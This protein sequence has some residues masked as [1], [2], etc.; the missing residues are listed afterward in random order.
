MRYDFYHERREYKLLL[1]GDLIQKK[2]Q[3]NQWSVQPTRS[4]EKER[5]KVDN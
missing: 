5:R 2:K 1:I 4:T 3:L